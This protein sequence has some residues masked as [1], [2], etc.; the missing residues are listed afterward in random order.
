MVGAWGGAAAGS[1]PKAS[2][3]LS[4]VVRRRV[5]QKCQPENWGFQK[6]LEAL[7]TLPPKRCPCPWELGLPEA[8]ET[9]GNAA[10]NALPPF[11]PL[12][13]GHSC[14]SLVPTFPGPLRQVF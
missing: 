8:P 12:G 14:P 3:L 9:P 1:S 7:G 4:R 13:A 5:G 2:C 10:P 11:P 6:P